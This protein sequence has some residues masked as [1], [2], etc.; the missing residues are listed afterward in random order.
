[1]A[2]HVRRCP[3]HAMIKAGGVAEWL[4]APVLKTGIPF[5]VSRVRIPPPPFEEGWEA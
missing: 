1:M 3:L 4:N 2:Y 5:G